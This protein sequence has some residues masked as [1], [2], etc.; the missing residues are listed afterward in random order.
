MVVPNV[1]NNT[2]NNQENKDK[3]DT[4]GKNAKRYEIKRHGDL[5]RYKVKKSER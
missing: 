3:T 5:N 1:G 2:G 4:N